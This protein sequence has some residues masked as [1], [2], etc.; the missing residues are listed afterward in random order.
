MS[1]VYKPDRDLIYVSPNTAENLVYYHSGMFKKNLC[2]AQVFQSFFHHFHWPFTTNF[3]P[4]CTFANLEKKIEFN[5]IFSF[6]FYI[7]LHTSYQGSRKTS[8]LSSFLQ[9]NLMRKKQKE[10][11]FGNNF[12]P[13]RVLYKKSVQ[14]FCVQNV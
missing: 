11:K 9:K 6:I 13:H 10:W 3:R 12:V 14:H 5:S 2:T 1:P 7:E 4:D 8:N